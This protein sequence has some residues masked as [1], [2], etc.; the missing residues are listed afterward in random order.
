MRTYYYIQQIIYKI[1]HTKLHIIYKKLFN[2]WEII[3]C[4]CD[5]R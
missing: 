1:L 5:T 2:E 4:M 3:L